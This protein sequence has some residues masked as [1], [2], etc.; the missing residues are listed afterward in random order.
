MVE[1]QLKTQVA[2]K[3]QR[4]L[5]V[6]EMAKILVTEH[7]LE[8]M[9]AQFLS[10]LIETLKAA[11]AGMLMLYDPSDELLKMG[12]AQGYDLN[13]LE[14][15]RLAPGEA[16][17]GK[18]FQT[19]QAES[20]PNPQ[21]IAAAR[22]N[23][24]PANRE[25]LKRAAVGLGQPQSVICIPL[26]TG[27]TIVGVLLLENRRQPDSFA[28]IDLTFLQAVADLIALA[29]EN[30]RLK[31]DLK[32]IESLREANRLKA[33]LLSTLAHEMRT[34]LTS[35]KG[36]STALLEEEVTLSP[37]TQQ[38]FLEIIDEGCDVLQD[39]IHDL[40][41]SSIIDAGLL[42]LELQPVMLPR[43]A[44]GVIDEIA[45]QSQN[46]RFLVDFPKRFPIVDADP[47]RI[48]QVLRNL[49]DNAVK[50]SPQGGL[51]VVRG[52]V[53]E[54]EIVISVA[55]Q[56]VGLAPEHLNQLF[57]KFFRAQSGLSLNVGGTGLGLPIAH[58]IVESHK[59]RIWAES[60]LGQGSTFYFTIPLEGLSQ[61]LEA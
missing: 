44:K 22:E 60:Q 13:G 45:H 20:Y 47:N 57:D 53:G 34:P 7:D 55:D 25:L 40:L 35:I 1:P 9:P 37:E 3:D 48:A 12:V 56:G 50:Y 10:C 4:L 42:R 38:E 61:G 39:L 14:S 54:S 41:E 52:E 16:M 36:Y 5:I 27:Q 15:L 33:E 29:I 23:M 18:I 58:T 19:G 43:L 8:M 17:T 11:E 51:I 24:T 21:A 49:L 26:I 46:H 28:H 31:E 2:D 32:T 6:F 30:V 59:G